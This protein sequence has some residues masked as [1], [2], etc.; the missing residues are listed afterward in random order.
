M[1]LENGTPSAS[2]HWPRG[3]GCCPLP[4]RYDAA[5]EAISAQGNFIVAFD[6]YDIREEVERQQVRVRAEEG[7]D[8]I[9]QGK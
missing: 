5:V 4:R 7:T 9:Y 6:G 1:R 8:V 2:R 3:L